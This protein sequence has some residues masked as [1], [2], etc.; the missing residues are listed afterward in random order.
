MIT[1]KVKPI[2]RKI[3]INKCKS[4][5]YNTGIVIGIG[6]DP[7]KFKNNPYLE[8]W[9]IASV[10][11]KIKLY[12]KSKSINYHDHNENMKA[13]DIIEVIVDRKLGNLSFA[14]NDVNYGIACSEIPKEDTLYPIVMINDQNQILMLIKRRR[15]LC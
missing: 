10:G 2:R 8:C 7:K 6:P 14:L 1:K 4:N 15:D 5:I 13:G 12:L 11:S 9:S 3:K